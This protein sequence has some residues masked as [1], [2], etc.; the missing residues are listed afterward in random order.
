MVEKVASLSRKEKIIDFGSGEGKLSVRLG[1]IPGVKEILAIEP[2]ETAQLGAIERFEKEKKAE[3]YVTPTPLLGSLF[4]YDE[5]LLNKDVIILCEVIEHVAEYRL[6]KIM[7]TIFNEYKPNTLIVTTPNRDYN[8]VNQMDEA[9]RHSDHRFE[10]TREEFTSHCRVWVQNVPYTAELE[11]I[12][13]EHEHYGHPTQMCTFMR[14]EGH[15]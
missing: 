8:A 3:G 12:G 10:W 13:Q 4:Y 6:Q 2:S 1:Y 11:G 9:V 14:K 15:A 5:R 7:K